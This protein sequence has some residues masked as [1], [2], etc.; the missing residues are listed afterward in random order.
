MRAAALLSVSLAAA[1]G[2]QNW[3]NLGG[4]AGRNG[5]CAVIGPDAP[6][7]LW[8]A[9]LVRSSLIAWHPVIEGRRVFMVRQTGF[10]PG[11]EPDGSPIVALD[12]DTGAELWFRHIPFNAGDWTTWIAG[13]R[14]GRVYAGRSG[15]GASVSAKLHCLDAA[16]GRTLWLS[17]DAIDAG[18]YDGVVFAPD[19][20]PIIASFQ[21]IWRIDA[22]TGA[23]VWSTSRVCSV[24]GN[25]G[26]A[27]FGDAIYVADA[28]P[29]GHSIRKFR[30]SDGAFQY[31]SQVMPGFTLQNT[32]MI[33]PDGTIYL[34]RTQNN[35]AVDSF[36]AF[37]DTGST[38]VR[39]WNVPCAASYASEFGI[40]PDG[41]V[42]MFDN[43]PGGG[44]RI[45]RLNP[46]SGAVLHS[47]QVIAA[48]FLQPHFAIDATGRVFVSNGAFFNGRVYSFNP[49]LTLRWSIAVPNANQGSPAL[50]PD[51]TLIL[52]GTGA[53]VRAYRTPHCPADFNGDG[54]LDFFDFDDF[55][56][57]FEG[58]AC[59]PGK[60][61]D[62]NN[63]GF[64]DF[65]DF[66]DFVIAFE[67]GC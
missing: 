18:A 14:G 19:G 24:S 27:I 36:Y 55:V 65:F 51:G 33:G 52:A 22:Q 10:P 13:V 32:P 44:F 35:A 23:T 11:G 59:P 53:N 49:D 3:S 54:F 20:D 15:N 16:T 57:C 26:G 6:D 30:L 48:D 29:G 21:T 28:V 37:A 61:A 42:Y 25:C 12:L 1:A 58:G 46:N 47:Y 38:L 60:S 39:K 63:D 4:N 40:G 9:G 43:A 50:G 67:A 2:A 7:A 34:A 41:S 56:A 31:Q 5:Q 45:Q 8:P 17:D 66:D 62:F 64:A